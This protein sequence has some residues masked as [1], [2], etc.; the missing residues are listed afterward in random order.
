[1]KV[2]GY[3]L[4]PRATARTAV[5]RRVEKPNGSGN[6][7]DDA[8]RQPM[9]VLGLIERRRRQRSSRFDTRSSCNAERS[10]TPIGFAAQVIG[11][12]LDAGRNSPIAAARVYARANN[13]QKEKRLVGIL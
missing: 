11:Q 1:M 9:Q 3:S 2:A 10:G 4:V 8:G 5:S 12:I 13:S 7:G 6:L